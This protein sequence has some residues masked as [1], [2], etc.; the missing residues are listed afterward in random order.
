MLS[1]IY[2]DLINSSELIMPNSEELLDELFSCSFS[3]GN[4]SG[5]T[6]NLDASLPNLDNPDNNLFA[7]MEEIFRENKSLDSQNLDFLNSLL[8]LDHEP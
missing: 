2:Q 6:P 7:G 4:P 3:T 5:V 1:K 8:S